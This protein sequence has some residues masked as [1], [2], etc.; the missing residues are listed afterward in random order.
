MY[1]RNVRLSEIWIKDYW[2]VFNDIIKSKSY[3]D[4]VSYIY[5]Y[6]WFFYKMVCLKLEKLGYVVI[7]N[8]R[9]LVFLYIDFVLFMLL[10]V[11]VS[12]Y[13]GFFLFSNLRVWYYVN[14]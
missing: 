6:G 4:K 2:V 8:L 10:I 9:V 13:C 14:V 5:V 3:R 7:S 11:M 12:D 1:I